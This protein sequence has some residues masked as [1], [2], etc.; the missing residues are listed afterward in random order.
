[1]NRQTPP[2]KK[3]NHR[4]L[5][6]IALALI[7][8]AVLPLNSEGAGFTSCA[9]MP[10]ECCYG[11][12]KQVN[13]VCSSRGTCAN[14]VCICYSAFTGTNCEMTK[15]CGSECDV[16]CSGHGTCDSG[17][18]VC[19]AGYGG[20]C[21]NSVISVDAALSPSAID[22]GSVVVGTPSKARTATVNVVVDSVIAS[23]ALSGDNSSDFSLGGTCAQG[24]SLSSGGAC[25]VTVA[26][27]PSA[28]GSRNAALTVK[29]GQ[30]AKY[31]ASSESGAPSVTT[32]A[33]TDI[34]QTTVTANATITGLG[35]YAVVDHG[36][37]WSDSLLPDVV[38]NGG[39]YTPANCTSLGAVAATG[40][41]SVVITGLSPDTTYHLRPYVIGAKDGNYSASAQYSGYGA[42]V[43]V[44][45]ASASDAGLSPAA[46]T[47]LTIT[48]TGTGVISADS[49]VIDP[50][51]STTLYAGLNGA[52]VYK[53][54]NS[55]ANWA[56]ATTQPANKSVKAL[57]I[58]K[59]DTKIL[60]AGTYG[61]GVYK[62]VD[63]GLTWA[64]CAT[65]QAN[66]YIR[67][68][69][70][71]GNGK[72]YAGTEAGVFVS[73]DACATWTAMNTGLP[74]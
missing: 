5:P 23:R 14:R 38:Y 16:L 20:K 4:M 12:W 1:M 34:T 31:P 29:I 74:E 10:A 19:E 2:A 37:C 59:G 24:N 47:A 63:S 15:A 67:S 43:S 44:H 3:T 33:V 21:C 39:D 46:D 68:L 25:T 73:A 13:D 45:T 56:A 64:A 22:F 35:S 69:S 65:N 70:I 30:A 66:L 54:L 40:A 7:L 18:C 53:S 11:I 32:Q 9:L 62:S 52:G 27:T 51:T 48:L 8:V 58:N 60:Y 28:A 41:F 36:V 72:L 61:G 71:D 26:F 49:I 55:G 17:Q 6:L 42:S 50:V 57:V